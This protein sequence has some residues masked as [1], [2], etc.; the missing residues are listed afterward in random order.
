LT[1]LEAQVRAAIR[2]A[3]NQESRKPFHW[4]GLA[5][6]DQLEAIAQALNMVPLEAAGTGYL[7]HLT[8]RV[9]HTI[10]RF[11]VNAED[12]RAAHTWLK[13]IAACLRY[14]PSAN[15]KAHAPDSPL[16]SAQVK[17]E[18]EAL[19]TEFKPDLKR[20]PAQAALYRAW[21]R[22]WEDS[23]SSWLP[24]YDIHGLPPDNLALEAVFGRLRRHQR[25]VSGC[26]STRKLRDFG[27]F[28]VLFLADSEAE[29][30]NQLQQVPLGEY[31]RHRRRLTEAESPRRFLHRLHRDPLATMRHLLDQH[32]AR[33]VELAAR[34]LTAL[35]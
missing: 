1:E 27:Q 11:R 8:T 21:H 22:I 25:R 3:V 5:G 18:L 31:E 23:G 15:P 30:L 33:R 34:Q 16:T 20:Q 28:Q 7:K 14:P 10:A 4:G 19:L 2:D 35:G 29:L 9:N 32:A 6:Y 12:L 17:Q 24:C 13:R 26:K